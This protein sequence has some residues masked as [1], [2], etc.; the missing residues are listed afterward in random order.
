MLKNQQILYAKSALELG[1]FKKASHAHNISEPA[2]SRNIASLEDSL[3]VKLFS[4]HSTGV[5]PTVYG[6]ALAKHGEKILVAV[7]EFEREIRILKGLGSGELSVALGPY[8]AELSGHR[9]FARLIAEHPDLRGEI[10]VSD[11]HK[12]EELVVMRKADLAIAELSVAQNNKHLVVEPLSQHNFV[13]FC[14]SGHPLISKNEIHKYDLSHYPLVLIKLPARLSHIFPGKLFPIPN[15][16]YVAPSIEVHEVVISRQIVASSD[17]VSVAIPYQIRNELSEGIFTIL[18]ILEPWMVSNYGFIY[19]KDRTLSPVAEK[20]I[21]L[22]KKIEKDVGNC[23]LK[24]IKNYL[25]EK[26]FL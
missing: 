3:G 21:S 24:L 18:P 20:Y 1:S 10:T 8:P 23:N 26:V 13:F 5:A 15:T 9:A 14:R 16:D 2:F 19:V 22:V 4:R 11:W 12:V 17:A 6:Q 7:S 25:P